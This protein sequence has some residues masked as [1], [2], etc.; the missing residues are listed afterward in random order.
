[1]YCITVFIFCITVFFLLFIYSRTAYAMPFSFVF[2]HLPHLL[3]TMLT[4]SPFTMPTEHNL[5]FLI[6]YSAVSVNGCDTGFE[7]Y[8]NI[9]RLDTLLLTV[10]SEVKC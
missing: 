3:F 5:P 8:K 4:F 2:I 1:M 6:Q 7:S 10:A 9:P